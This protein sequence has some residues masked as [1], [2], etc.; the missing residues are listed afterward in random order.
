MTIPRPLTGERNESRLCDIWEDPAYLA[1]EREAALAIEAVLGRWPEWR[2]G[3]LG[4][5]GHWHPNGFA[6]FELGNFQGLSVR[7]HFWP[8]EAGY[9]QSWHPPIHSHDRHVS[10]VVLLGEKE[11]ILWNATPKTDAD[12]EIYGVQRRSLTQELLIPT[13]RLATA[14]PIGSHR[15]AQG[16]FFSQPA[17]AYH[18]IPVPS[19]KPFATLCVK[20]SP[21]EGREQATLDVAG[22]A[23]RQVDRRRVTPKELRL[24]FS[25]LDQEF[26]GNGTERNL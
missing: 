1:Y 15:Y 10:S 24:I 21:I 11:D 4:A 23:E 9:S 26:G 13:A 22:L 25:T 2:R 5:S 12:R 18:E 7:L 20:S 14:A 17:G 3:L 16:A 19:S 8:A 6:S